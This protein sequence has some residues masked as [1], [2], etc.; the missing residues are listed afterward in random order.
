MQ[1]I[2]RQIVRYLCHA[3]R[4]SIDFMDSNGSTPLQIACDLLSDPIIIESI[5]G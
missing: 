5:L 4:D 1:E 3:A 2:N